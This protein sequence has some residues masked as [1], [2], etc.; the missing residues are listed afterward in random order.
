MEQR[1]SNREKMNQHIAYKAAL[2]SI[3]LLENKQGLPLKT[4]QIALFG[5]GSIYTLFSGLG[6]GEVN[7]RFNINILNGLKQNNVE[8][9]SN[10]YLERL[11]KEHDLTINN[12]KKE[13]NKKLLKLQISD[14][15]NSIFFYPKV[16]DILL[17]E[18][19]LNLNSDTAVY[20]ISRNSSE[21]ID[22]Q[23]KK[24]EYYLTDTELN[25]LKNLSKHYKDL[26]IIINSGY[27]ID[28]NFLEQLD[29]YE[30][31]VYSGYLGMMGG[32]ALSNVLTGITSPSGKLSSTWPK[33]IEDVPN[34]DEFFSSKDD[35]NY[36]EGIFVGYRYYDTFNVLPKYSFGHG[37][38]YSNFTIKDTKINNEN[39]IFTIKTTLCN[40]G[41]TSA[42]E[43]V[44]AFLEA[45]GNLNKPKNILVGFNKSDDILPNQFE[46]I[47]IKFDLFDFASYDSKKEA[48]VIEKGSYK[49]KVGLSLDN[50]IDEYSFDI[51]ED[52]IV[53]E[54]KNLTN[55]NI[56]ETLSNKN[57]TFNSSLNTPVINT[58]P[59]TINYEKPNIEINSNK[60]PKAMIKTLVGNGFT[61]MKDHAIVGEINDL[62]GKKYLL[63]DGPAGLRVSQ[64]SN[65][66]L[67]I[68]LPSDAPIQ[69]INYFPSCF[70][71]LVFNKKDRKNTTYMYPTC[72][73][74][75]TN[76]AQTFN[77]KLVNEIGI[78]IGFEMK[79]FN[80]SYLL[81]PAINVQRNPFCGRNFEYFS[82]DPYLSGIMGAS[83]INGIKQIPD[84]NATIKHFC[85]NN[86]EERRNFY[87]ANINDEALR[88]I[89]LK[90]F[91][92]AIKYS[93]PGALMS[94][95]NK[96]NHEY[97]AT[98]QKLINDYL[99]CELGYNGV[100]MTDWYA[101]GKNKA[102]TYQVIKANADLIMPGSKQDLNNLLK[103]YHHGL[104][105]DEEL[106]RSINRLNN[107][108]VINNYQDHQ[109]Y[110]LLSDESFLHNK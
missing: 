34:V 67:G 68:R 44:L 91:E 46:T 25:N 77:Q 39:N 71:N 73:P 61:S 81:A 19:D 53:K 30:A 70:V 29:H 7:P 72:F 100:V 31:V 14:I 16:D 40:Q 3:V 35:I 84:C 18:N 22:N 110:D 15:A 24:G 52:I 13:I 64:K 106:F 37:L 56:K 2:E 36:N 45:G 63:S 98:S 66:L 102:S 6:S 69:S 92:I 93:N 21:N 65:T 85:C 28:M 87:S 82:E 62:T 26:I 41:N 83:L 86:K 94:S 48:Y 42:K 23:P 55:N 4:N 97:V 109:F 104:L 43:S 10:N 12:Y 54:V 105:T 90:P 57:N 38:T 60:D 8:I 103:A 76:L 50:I 79:E 11:E 96:V 20:V 95:Y 108:S 51:K 88:E 9:L 47:T 17:D 49:L 33:K 78:G 107:Y 101:T 89:Y 32:A 74:A 58:Q 1:E 99:R 27:P 5:T 80:V 75:A 59:S